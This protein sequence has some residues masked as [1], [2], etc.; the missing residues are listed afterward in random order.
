MGHRLQSNL[1]NWDNRNTL[2][3][4]PDNQDLIHT[5]GGLTDWRYSAARRIVKLF[6]AALRIFVRR[7]PL[8]SMPGFSWTH[9]RLLAGTGKIPLSISM[10]KL[11]ESFNGRYSE[12]YEWVKD[13]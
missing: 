11:S 5:V 3:S 9:F 13:I 8:V 4:C 10:R 12:R 1:P 6:L 7:R 2:P